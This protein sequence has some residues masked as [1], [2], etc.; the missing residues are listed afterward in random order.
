MKK[1]ARITSKGQITVPHEIRRASGVLP[2]DKLLSRWIEISMK[3]HGAPRAF[4]QYV[5]RRRKQS[6]S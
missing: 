1:A 3:P 2:V 5:A 6:D 4:Q